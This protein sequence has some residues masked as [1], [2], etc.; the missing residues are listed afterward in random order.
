MNYC[1]VGGNKKRLADLSVGPVTREVREL[2]ASYLPTWL[3][4]LSFFFVL[5]YESIVTRYMIFALAETHFVCIV[6]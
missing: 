2:P 6:G 5:E 1:A 4:F 3:V